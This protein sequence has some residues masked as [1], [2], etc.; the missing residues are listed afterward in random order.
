M[1]LYAPSVVSEDTFVHFL[2][3]CCEMIY[4]TKVTD[5][6]DSSGIVFDALRFWDNVDDGDRNSITIYGNTVGYSVSS[7]IGVIFYVEVNE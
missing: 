3:L 2:D 4:A 6:Y 1:L 7:S 5:S